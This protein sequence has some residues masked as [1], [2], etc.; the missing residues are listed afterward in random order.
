MIR[1]EKHIINIVYLN[2]EHHGKRIK[3]HDVLLRF[4]SNTM[5]DRLNNPVGYFLKSMQKCFYQPW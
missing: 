4:M 5:M 1:R 3:V 2:I